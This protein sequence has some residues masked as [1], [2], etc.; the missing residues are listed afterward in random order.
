MNS[1]LKIQQ[2]QGLY[3]KNSVLCYLQITIKTL[4]NYR[5]YRYLE[6]NSYTSFAII[7]YLL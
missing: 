6:L 4:H 2:N 7:C 1:I 3:L 5:V